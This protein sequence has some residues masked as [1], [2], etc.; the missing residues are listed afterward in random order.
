MMDIDQNET[1]RSP[2]SAYP[3]NQHSTA[4]SVPSETSAAA[5]H[6]G[7]GSADAQNPSSP[8]KSVTSLSSV[9]N[10]AN[11]ALRRA[12]VASS[13]TSSGT[14]PT[15]THQRRPPIPTYVDPSKRKCGNCGTTKSAGK[16]RRD[17]EVPDS[18]LCNKCGMNQRRTQLRVE[19]QQERNSAMALALASGQPLPPQYSKSERSSS[20]SSAVV[21]DSLLHAPRLTRSAKSKN[22]PDHSNANATSEFGDAHAPPSADPT[23]V[24]HSAAN[25]QTT[26]SAMAQLRRNALAAAMSR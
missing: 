1:T 3:I 4:A 13:T 25:S 10:A 14:G 19:Q 21:D 5:F 6:S 17:R 16:W 24:S 7:Y 11:A 8:V 15:K 23:I 2:D 9:A 12:S 26:A 18:Y 20:L 22:A